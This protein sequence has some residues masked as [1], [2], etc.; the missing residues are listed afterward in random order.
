MRTSTFIGNCLLANLAIIFFVFFYSST[1]NVHNLLQPRSGRRGRVSPYEKRRSLSAGLTWTHKFVCLGQTDTENI[2]NPQDKY[3]LKTAGL[4]EKKLV[5][6]LNG[7]YA[8]IKEIILEAFP[9]LEKGGGFELSRTSGP[10]SRKLMPIDPSFLTSVSKL[11]E[12]VDQAR[13]YIR[14]LQADIAD[15]FGL[16]CDDDSQTGDKV[17]G[18]VGVLVHVRACV[19]VCAPACVCVCAWVCV[20]VCMWACVCVCMCVRMYGCVCVCV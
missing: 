2:P 6:K 9:L 12:F 11:K 18:C 3:T 15:I 1:F 7:N 16:P 4:G 20:Y 13:V 10:Y 19:Y 14:P 8:H 17:C 5:F